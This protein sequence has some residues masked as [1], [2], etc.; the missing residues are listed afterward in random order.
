MKKML[1][2][3]WM[4][5]VFQTFVIVSSQSLAQTN[6]PVK[7]VLIVGDSLSAGYGIK[8]EQSWPSLLQIKLDQVHQQGPKVTVHNVSISGQT[9]VEGAAQIEQLLVNTSPDL[10]ILE[11]GAND[12]LRGLSIPEMKKNLANIIQQSQQAKAKVLLLGMHVPSNYGRRYSQMFHNT[13][14]QLADEY[15]TA[16]VPFMLETV[17]TRKEFI[18]PDGLHPTAEAQ[19]LILEHLWR[20]IEQGVK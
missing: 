14:Q 10:V 7:S 17:A 15:N 19:P 1:N 13:F 9:S 3:V 8:V 12:G 4:F 5:V 18:Q 2:A 11:L 16:L 6:E 20:E